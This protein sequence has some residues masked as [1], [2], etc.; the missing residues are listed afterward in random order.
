MHDAKPKSPYKAPLKSIPEK[1]MVE[2]ITYIVYLAPG[3]GLDKLSETIGRD[4]TPYVGH[5]LD[6][7]YYV[8]HDQVVFLAERVDDELLEAIRS[9]V[10]V[11][12]V[13]YNPTW[14]IDDFPEQQQQGEG[15]G[16]Q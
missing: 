5:V 10:G 12:Q 8:K 9:D 7:D 11:Q 3:H 4:I 16:P 13:E 2:P 15:Y 6:L 14:P 1:Y